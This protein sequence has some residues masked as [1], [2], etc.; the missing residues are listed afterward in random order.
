MALIDALEVRI[1][2][3][4]IERE[5]INFTWDIVNYEDESIDLQLNI[6]NPESI[7][8]DFGE[9]DTLSITFWGTKFFK[10]TAGR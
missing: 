5:P 2:Q 7:G 8:D 4:D 1:L 3:D 9:P 6:R 10:S